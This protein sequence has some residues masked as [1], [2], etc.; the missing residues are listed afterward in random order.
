MRVDPLHRIGEVEQRTLAR[1]GT[2][3]AHVDRRHRRPVENDRGNAG[4]ECCVIGMTDADAGNIGEEIFQG[5][6][7][8]NADTVTGRRGKRIGAQY[9]HAR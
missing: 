2:A 3:A 9:D 6:L 1:A 7:L 5:A 4:R 8:R